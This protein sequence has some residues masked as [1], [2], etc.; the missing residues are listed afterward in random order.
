MAKLAMG[1]I[2]FFSSEFIPALYGGARIAHTAKDD[3]V[4]KKR[5]IHRSPADG[6]PRLAALAQCT[7]RLRLAQG[8]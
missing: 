4:E 3:T 6:C 7:V 1:M 5:A 8:A 2:V